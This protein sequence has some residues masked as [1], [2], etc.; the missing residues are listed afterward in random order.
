MAEYYGYFNGIE[1][2]EEFVALVN[3]ILVKNG[4]FDDG[5]IVSA[6]EGM[7]VKAAIGAAIVNG[8]IYYNDSPLSLA[9]P[10]ANASL[11]RMDS[12]M[13]R[14]NI[15]ARKMNLLLLE[16]TPQSNPS[17]PIPIR[18]GTYY[19]MQI[20]VIRVNAGVASITAA[21][22]TDTRPDEV[23]CGITSG[24]NSVDIDAMMTQYRA[25]FN[26]WFDRIKDQLDTDAAGNLQNQIDAL[27]DSK[28][29]KNG[30]AGVDEN[31]K[32]Y[33]MPSREDVAGVPTGTIVAR[34]TQTGNVGYLLCDGRAVS[35][36]TYADLFA[37]INTGYGPG[38]GSTTFNLPDYTGR[39]LVGFLAGDKAFGSAGRFGGEQTHT[40]TSQEIPVTPVNAGLA[41]DSSQTDGF[42][43][44]Y[45][46]ISSSSKAGVEGGDQPHNNLQPYR[47][48]HW[49]IKY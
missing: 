47:T 10:T 22:I 36:T 37:Q 41:D 27:I 38:D 16:G 20:A 45:G 14:W 7:T 43:T 31:G 46:H 49:F 1:Y 44:T 48:I 23:V 13:L 42:L 28:G 15:P 3:R 39:V 35:R 25:E 24:Y 40:L 17:P 32:L 26:D 6:S 4:V 11:P 12:I 18:N 21:N 30:I 8:F 19:D 2:D 5:L 29:Q 9:I 33:P 34:A